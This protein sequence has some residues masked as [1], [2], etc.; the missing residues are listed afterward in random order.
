[1]SSPTRTYIAHKLQSFLDERLASPSGPFTEDTR[2]FSSGLF[3]SL[4]FMEIVL[5]VETEFGKSLIKHGEVNLETM[6]RW[7]DLVSTV[8]RAVREAEDARG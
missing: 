8:E 6:D 7:G 5:F 2:L 3:D 1:V 4:A